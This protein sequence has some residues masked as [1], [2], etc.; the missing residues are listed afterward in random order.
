MISLS[1]KIHFKGD[2]SSK[3]L[4]RSQDVALNFNFYGMLNFHHIGRLHYNKE[5]T[6]MKTR[7]TRILSLAVFFLTIG[8]SKIFAESSFSTQESFAKKLDTED[9]LKGFR[10]HFHIPHENGKPSLY[11]NANSLG[12]QPRKAAEYM[13]QELKAWAELGVKGHFKSE[14]PWYTYNAPLR[15]P[16]AKIVGAKGVE[17]V[18]F[19]NALTVNLHL[20]MVSF[21]QPT[22]N[23][24]KILM[25]AP[26]F[27]SDT[28]AVK[29]QLE[30]HGYDPEDAL[31]IVKPRLGEHSIRTEDVEAALKKHEG[32]VALVL[33]NG[34][35]FLTGQAIDVPTLAKISHDHG[36]FFGLDLAHTIGNVPLKLHDWGVD[37]AAWC[38]YKYLSGG[39][40]AAGGVFIHE[41]HATN[42]KLHRFAGWWG[43]DPNKRFMIQL[44]KEF[45]PVPSAN[46]WQISNPPLFCLIPQRASL[47]LFSQAGMPAIR[48]KSKKMT[49]Y[50]EF[51][52][53]QLPKGMLEIITPR[54]PDARGC[55]LSI[56]I[57]GGDPQEYH[58]WLKKNHV[59]CDFRK[60]DVIRVA[61]FPLYNTY[62][63]V[64]RFAEI[65]KKYFEKHRKA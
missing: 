38:G 17:E 36:A 35:N 37:F 58:Q 55:Q 11:L 22:K 19:M 61:P 4:D 25:E 5:R 24:Y 8:G 40:G 54:N 33:L 64:W 48:E 20:M 50:L 15:E 57:K 14:N 47:E 2:F 34:V 31:V 3:Q 63:E 53:D 41:K 42:L 45:I 49:G 56:V 62:H 27:S 23:K 51:L 6:S 18:V 39:P 32:E 7:I 9:P 44:E 16:I 28:Y 52:L 13:N 29:T 46:S 12:L 59:V 65:T 60:P 21:Y 26:V 43:N 1:R 30:H 10:A